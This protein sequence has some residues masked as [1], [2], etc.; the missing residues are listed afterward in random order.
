MLLVRFSNFTVPNNLTGWVD[1]TA[2]SSAL[3]VAN[4][5]ADD[6][7]GG[8][9]KCLREEENT[10]ALPAPLPG[11]GLSPTTVRERVHGTGL[12]PTTVSSSRA[13]APARTGLSP[14]IVVA[15]S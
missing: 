15:S 8:K 3:V 5:I 12:S 6:S 11:T 10:R 4:S 9:E 1:G 13:P 14:T 2:A 7:G